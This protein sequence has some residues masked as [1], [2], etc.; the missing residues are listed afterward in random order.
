MWQRVHSVRLG[1]RHVCSRR[2]ARRG[3]I[4]DRVRATQALGGQQ[5]RIG[6]LVVPEIRVSE[7]E[8]RTIF[9]VVARHLA[10]LQD[11]RFQP[12]AARGVSLLHFQGEGLHQDGAVG[13][14]PAPIGVVGSVGI[15]DG[16]ELDLGV[17]WQRQ[18][19][20]LLCPV[21][22]ERRVHRIGNEP[23]GGPDVL[24]RVEEARLAELVREWLRPGPRRCFD[25]PV[26]PAAGEVHEIDL[27][28]LVL[29]EFDDPDLGVGQLM[30]VD[31]L[32]AIDSQ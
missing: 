23:R 31:H 21:G 24:G 32:A 29:G 25:Q 8:L 14:S 28:R 2:A 27:A 9:V 22:P 19:A 7:P 20:F 1:K 11:A 10:M 26:E 12:L 13:E 17:P 30:V 6:L 16:V 18:E 3:G 5:V 4:A 15:D